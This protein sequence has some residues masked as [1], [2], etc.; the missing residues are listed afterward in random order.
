MP[1]VF[2]LMIFRIIVFSLILSGCGNKYFGTVDDDYTP[3]KKIIYLNNYEVEFSVNNLE[4]LP[5]LLFKNFDIFQ[6]PKLNLKTVNFSKIKKIFKNESISNIVDFDNSLIYIAKNYSL[7]SFSNNKIYSK[8]VLPKNFRKNNNQ[9]K[10]VLE[11]NTLFVISDYGEI[12]K[13]SQNWSFEPLASANKKINFINSHE[14]KFLFIDLNGTLLTFDTIQNTFNISDIMDVN[15]GFNNKN[16]DIRNYNNLLFHNI[17]TKTFAI[18]DLNNYK[19]INKYVLDSLNILSSIGD[20][21][22]LVN[23]P[24][25]VENGVIFV[26]EK[27]KIFNFDINNDEIIWNLDLN[28]IVIDFISSPNGLILITD[29]NMHVYETING[30]LISKNKHNVFNPTLISLINS[31]LLVIGQNNLNFIDFNPYNFDASS[32]IKF[33][34]NNIDSIGYSNGNYF[35]KNKDNIYTLSE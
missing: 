14:G 18:I 26:S 21:E 22:G 6:A 7:K 8:S 24:L 35:L 5:E 20:V 33:K 12:F 32:I 34:N 10:I 28:E 2:F 9:F 13:I 1:L 11:N 4:L 16:Y 30:K 19:F 17:N 15:Y 23:T 29:T 27:G 25:I 3:T 31:K